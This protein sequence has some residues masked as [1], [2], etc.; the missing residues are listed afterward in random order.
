MERWK[1]IASRLARRIWFRATVISVLSVFLALAA[2]ALAPLI[3]Y[4]LSLKI[5][6]EAVDNILT[7]L[8]SSMLAVATF[9]MAAMV[10]AF[11]A[12]SQNVTPRAAQLLIEDKTAQNALSTFIGAFLFGI[13]GIIALS[14]GYYGAEGRA[15]LFVGTGLM[16][17]WVVITLL[18]WIQQ[19][20][21]FGRMADTICRIED[22][23]KE[24]VRDHPGHYQLSGRDE[25]EPPAGWAA[26]LGQSTGHVT[27]IDM[28]SIRDT[29]ERGKLD[30][31][32][33]VLP[34]QFVDPRQPL[35]WTARPASEDHSAEIK[36]AF[37]IEDNRQ[38][39]HDPRFG[40]VVLSEI[41]S[42]ALSPAV[43]DPGSAIAV[44]TAVQRVAETFIERAETVPE[45]NEIAGGYGLSLQE[46]ME[47]VVLPI[48]RDG[49]A[50]AEVGIRLQLVLGSLAEA[51]PGA[52]Y[53]ESLAADA[54]GRARKAGMAGRDLERLER[55]HR[56]AFP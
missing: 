3:P 10:T 32:L 5:G 6:A 54:M 47:D 33:A 36:H 37:T 31:H 44:L 19:L 49:A 53:L 15:I 14:T 51:A 46:M 34:G 16:V 39:N 42:R 18:R 48:A 22:A 41:A 11:S 55:V 17:G 29:C 50:M 28:E 8:A 40:M 2:S 35:A 27:H 30:L 20:T 1:W 4:D 26:V 12:A 7:I 56:R 38:F 13:V 24:A 9:S 52:S 45:E 23:A 25:A 43:N 21:S